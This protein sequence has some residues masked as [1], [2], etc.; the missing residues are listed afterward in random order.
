MAI[1]F[2]QEKRTQKTLIVILF[3]ILSITTFVIWNGFFK[4]KIEIPT[5]EEFGIIKKEVNINYGV[6]ELPILEELTPFF[7]IEPLEEATSTEQVELPETFGR[8]NPFIPY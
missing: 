5:D 8:E 2:L 6:L 1:I 4:E 7:N 3:V